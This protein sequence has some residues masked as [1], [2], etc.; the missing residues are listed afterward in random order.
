MHACSLPLSLHARLPLSLQWKILLHRHYLPFSCD[1]FQNS[2]QVAFV[3]CMVDP[4]QRNQSKGV[5]SIVCP[6]PSQ[7]HEISSISL[8][9]SLHGHRYTPVFTGDKKHRTFVG[10]KASIGAGLL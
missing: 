2:G 9:G 8:Y 4:A 7:L 5:Y 3:V 6:L 1:S 10:V